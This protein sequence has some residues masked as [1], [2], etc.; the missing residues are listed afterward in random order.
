[1]SVN[2]DELKKLNMRLFVERKSLIEALAAVPKPNVFPARYSRDWQ[3]FRPPGQPFRV[4][5]PRMSRIWGGVQHSLR[6]HPSLAVIVTSRCLSS[7]CAALTTCVILFLIT[8][9]AARL[10]F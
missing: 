10:T 1:M 4:K 2:L 8:V 9:D 5:S 3:R 7:F 6:G